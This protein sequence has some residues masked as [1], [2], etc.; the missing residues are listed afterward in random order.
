M[1]IIVLAAL[2]FIALVSATAPAAL[3]R[4]QSGQDANSPAT[5]LGPGGSGA[6]N[7]A[8]DTS[9]RELQ[10]WE[11]VDGTFEQGYAWRGLGLADPFYG[12]FA[13]G[14]QGPAQ[15]MGVRVYVTQGGYFA[16][17]SMDLFIWG[18]G[19][20]EPG[21]VLQLIPGLVPESI[22]LWPDVAGLEY[23]VEAAVGNNFYVGTQA[24]FGLSST[25]WNAVDLDGPGGSPWTC[26][27]PGLGFPVGWN[28]P[29]IVWTEFGQTKSMGYGVYIER[30]S[31][32]DELPGDEVFDPQTTWGS[33]KALFG[34]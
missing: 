3:A 31:S 4:V 26:I 16:G 18:D 1:R 10:Y 9:L 7:L 8:G 27:A 22:P 6:V 29:S 5:A 25:F 12:A 2:V 19:I 23:A 30:S 28:D 24:D 33:I 15:V 14:F 11:N 21:A 20:G 34:N 32:V 13:E 17:E